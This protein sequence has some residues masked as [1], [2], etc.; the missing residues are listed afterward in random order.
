[1]L[2]FPERDVLLKTAFETLTGTE[3]SYRNCSAPGLL[4]PVASD[5]P[6]STVASFIAS[7]RIR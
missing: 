1:M 5:T 7:P 3:K 6:L 2:H 4:R